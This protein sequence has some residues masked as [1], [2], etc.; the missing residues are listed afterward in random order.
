MYCVVL[1]LF[2][3]GFC[4]LNTLFK[5]PVIFKKL[6]NLLSISNSPSLRY[7][8]VVQN[9]L[10]LNTFRSSHR[11]AVSGMLP[12]GG[13]GGGVAVRPKIYQADRVTL[14]RPVMFHSCANEWSLK[15]TGS[16]LAYSICL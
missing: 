7:F 3:R 4:G 6:F 11:S 9:Q 10:F 8:T 2:L 1:L 5:I 14:S 13:E 16:I 12:S 15:C